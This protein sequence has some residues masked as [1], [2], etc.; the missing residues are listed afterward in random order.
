[1]R[2]APYPALPSP[3][4]LLVAVALVAAG[5]CQPELPDVRE[6]VTSL[7][8]VQASARV[9]DP[10][11]LWSQFGAEVAVSSL[12]ADGRLAFR[13]DLYVDRGAD[14]FRRAIASRQALLTQTAGPAGCTARWPGARDV[15]PEELR[16][17]G[18]AGEP[19]EAVLPPR[20][21]H[22][23]LIGL[24]MSALGPATRFGES[25]TADEA[26]GRAVTRVELSFADDPGGQTWHLFIEPDGKE[27]AGARFIDGRDAGERFAYGDYVDF[28]GFRLAQSRTVTKAVSEAFVIEQ[29]LRYEPLCR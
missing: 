21:L 19:C 14:T 5:A 27:L 17:N 1:M 12:T 13:E 20:D 18:L 28:G 2:H 15:S 26:F 4:L 10:A 7:E 25:P 11:G 22:E 29:R 16:R 23:F 3:A 6:P 8:W 9:H 24:P